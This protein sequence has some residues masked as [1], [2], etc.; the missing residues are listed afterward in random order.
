[1]QTKNSSAI[2]KIEIRICELQTAY[3]ALQEQLK[4]MQSD[5]ERKLDDS[6]LRIIG[7]LDMMDM[8]KS[9]MNLN[10]DANSNAQLIIKKLKKDRSDF[11]NIGK[12]KR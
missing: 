12:C 8:A 2:D 10:N 3:V 4:N 7:I 5:F 6:A 1:M 11:L 9:N